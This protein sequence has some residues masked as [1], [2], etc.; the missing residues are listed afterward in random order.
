MAKIR[1]TLDIVMERTKDLALTEEQKILMRLDEWS[2]KSRVL[3]QRY[4]AGT[5]TVQGFRAELKRGIPE[6]PE[7][8]NL[9]KQEFIQTLD[10][11]DDYQALASGFKDVLDI[12]PTPYIARMQDFAARRVEARRQISERALAGLREQGISGSAV[13]PNLENDP[14][15]QDRLAN[16]HAELKQELAGL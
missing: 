7:L 16:L 11:E 8:K 5:L 14:S 1:S 15:W 2:Q 13:L 6:C 3:V 10:T 12:D 9:V 4:R